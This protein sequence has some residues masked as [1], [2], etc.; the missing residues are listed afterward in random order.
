MI[1]ALSHP[2]ASL[3]K[4]APEQERDFATIAL[5]RH[6][7]AQGP[8]LQRFRDGRV[9]I[10]SGNGPVVGYPATTPATPKPRFVWLPLFG[11]FH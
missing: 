8:V 5:S 11:G 7:S 6:Q 1:P 9:E 10:D 4:A 3:T 2:Q